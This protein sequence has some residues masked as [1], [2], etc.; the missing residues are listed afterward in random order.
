MK[1]KTG[2][3]LVIFGLE[4]EPVVNMASL[5]GHV[6]VS[7]AELFAITGA[8]SLLPS[9]QLT[10]RPMHIYS[11]SKLSLQALDKSRVHSTLSR[12]V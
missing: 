9:R 1:G 5:G 12:S 10:N 6:S 4:D 8:A 2:S 7:Q 3:S 11:D